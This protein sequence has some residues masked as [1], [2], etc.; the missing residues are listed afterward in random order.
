MALP[1]VNRLKRRQDFSLVYQQGNRYKSRHLTLRVL[2]QLST[3]SS[4]LLRSPDPLSP[5]PIRVGI[6]VSLK[7]NKRAVV[8]NLIRRRLQAAFYHL[9][10]YL[11]TGWDV[12]VIVHPL[13]WQCD[14]S[15]F[16]QE[17]EQLLTEAEVLHG[18]E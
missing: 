11:K 17:L 16:L 8:R 2:R 6:V 14:Y 18:R 5:W 12:V 4:P 15:Q 13:A 10:P 7:V 3:K 9:L 1:R